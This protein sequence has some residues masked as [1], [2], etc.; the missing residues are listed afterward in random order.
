MS[1]ASRDAGQD[2]VALAA[3]PAL[4]PL[5]ARALLTA[6]ARRAPVLAPGAL[7]L[8]A[9]VVDPAR[10]AGYARVCGWALADA[11]P[12][13]YPHVLALGAQV[14]LMVARPFPLPALGVVH[15]RQHVVQHRALRVGERASVR[16]WAQDLVPHPRGATVDV[17]AQVGVDGEPVWRGTSTYLSRGARAP[18]APAAPSGAAEPAEVEGLPGAVWRV[19]ADTGRRYAA[20]SGDVNPIHLSA[21][22]ARLLGFPRAIAHGMWT[23]ARALAPLQPHLGGPVTVDA[24]FRSPVLLPSTVA[25]TT[26]RVPGG[27]WDL[28]VRSPAGDRTHLVVTVHR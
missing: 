3:P 21:P 20:V 11:V 10:V 28:A 5:Y 7:V 25:L 22:T 8:D 14:H 26:G 16:V 2:D 4:G 23:L 18:E 19:P 9:G 12:L 1:A 15:V 24:A 27:G 13:T 6:R 17:V